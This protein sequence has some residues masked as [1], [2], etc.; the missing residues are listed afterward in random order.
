MFDAWTDWLVDNEEMYAPSS[1]FGVLTEQGGALGI[2]PAEEE[3]RSCV[4]YLDAI[5]VQL[6]T[7]AGLLLESGGEKVHHDEDATRLSDSDLQ[8]STADVLEDAG[9]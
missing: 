5:D 2:I 9:T 3:K 7:L 4:T 8:I 6:P 1:S